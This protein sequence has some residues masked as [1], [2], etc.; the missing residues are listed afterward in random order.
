MTRHWLIQLAFLM[1]CVAV[2][3]GCGKKDAD[4]TGKKF[5]ATPKQE[6]KDVIQ[7]SEESLKLVTIDVITV[8]HGTLALTLRAPGRISF[9]PNHTARVTSTFQGRIVKMNHDVG[10][11]VQEG[12][13]MALID[14]PELLSKSLEL[15]APISGQVIERHGTLGEI[16]DQTKELY[17]I[18]D[19]T[20]VWVLAAVN[21]NDIAAV[22]VG[23]QA[24]TYTM[25]YP[26]EAFAGQV[27]LIGPGVDE[28]SQAVEVRIGVDNQGAKL[29][30]GMFADV[31][32]VTSTSDNVVLI[33]DEAVQRLNDQPIVFVATDTRTF[34]KRPVKTGRAQNGNTEILDNLKDGE[35]VVTKGSFLL[36]SELL[37]SQLGE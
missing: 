27:V 12:D 9:N 20:N 33:P 26:D 2:L 14:S 25:A 1:A 36:K 35:R 13:V 16:V 31:D 5:E 21:A 23:Q 37:K 18:S 24:V 6:Q 34:T 8:G 3:T 17:I 15:K 28:K 10:A 7:L 30:P 29:K 22:R 32:I 4:E 19:P 11:P